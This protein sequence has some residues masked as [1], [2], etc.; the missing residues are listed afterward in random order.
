MFIPVGHEQESVRRFPAATFGI[1]ALCLVV[2]LWCQLADRPVPTE[3]A[4]VDEAF[5]RV[6][7]FWNSHPGCV[8]PERASWTVD[9]LPVEQQNLLEDLIERSDAPAVESAD[10]N[11]QQQFEELWYRLVDAVPADPRHIWAH[12]PWEPS[13]VRAITHMFVHEDW[14]H[15]FWNMVFLFVCAVLLEDV[16]GRGVFLGFYVLAGLVALGPDLLIFSDGDY[17]TFGASGAVSG[18]MGAFAFRFWNTRMRLLM[19]VGVI[20]RPVWVSSWLILAFWFVRN[21]AGIARQLAG[22][23]VDHLAHVAGFLFG[24][25]FALAMRAFAVEERGLAAAV[26]SKS[27]TP[28]IA[29]PHIE[30]SLDDVARGRGR[31]AARR[32]AEAARRE[33]ENVDT[34]LALWS[35]SGEAGRERGA[36]EAMTRAIAAE[37]RAGDLNNAIDHWRELVAEVSDATMDA[38]SLIR[39]AGGLVDR[40]MNQ[41][42][43]EMLQRA[44]ATPA[45][46]VSSASLLSIA[47]LAAEIDPSLSRSAARAVLDR[48]ES[49][50]YERKK[51]EELRSRRDVVELAP[52]P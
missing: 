51:A 43:V 28:I 30:R 2:L 22:G 48:P 40:G 33:P 3:V 46:R 37:L 18:V 45:K 17:V 7:D 15:F 34:A 29:N 47:S 38:P 27:S 20:A 25:L 42:A 50:L 49:T 1:I 8:L 9:R 35:V 23:G 21:V 19:L 44:L 5:Q 31:V 24:V 36:A 41:E 12:N 52:E 39:L 14:S 32:L 11:A 26:E 13:A 16:W 10:E 6:V 4:A